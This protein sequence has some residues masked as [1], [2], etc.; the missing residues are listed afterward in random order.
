[1]AVWNLATPTQPPPI[2]NS[3]QMSSLRGR[4]K[5]EVPARAE[6]FEDSKV[7]SV[8]SATSAVEAVVLAVR[9]AVRN[10]PNSAQQRLS[11]R[12]AHA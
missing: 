12:D 5:A 2:G 7:P 4:R 9:G 3:S 10:E 8:V 6:N 11:L 1:M